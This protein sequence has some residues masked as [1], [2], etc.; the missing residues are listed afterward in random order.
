MSVSLFL[1]N[2]SM[3][4]V[5]SKSVDISD[6]FS[7]FFPLFPSLSSLKEQECDMTL[8]HVKMKTK[9]SRLLNVTRSS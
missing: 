8:M 6:V 3:E 9:H 5:C 7:I 2:T 1:K 4:Y